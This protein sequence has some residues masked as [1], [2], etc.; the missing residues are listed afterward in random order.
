MKKG[1]SRSL[2]ALSRSD[3]VARSFLNISA[4]QHE[5]TDS[6]HGL[7]STHSAFANGSTKALG[8]T[9]GHVFVTGV[10]N[11]VFCLHNFTFY[12]YELSCRNKLITDYS[13]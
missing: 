13:N 9:L 5:S 11:H 10:I 4:D 2:F 6:R 1:S 8:Q 7:H 12:L 3:Q